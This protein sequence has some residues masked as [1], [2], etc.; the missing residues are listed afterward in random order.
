MLPENFQLEVVTPERRVIRATAV[1]VQVPAQDGYLGVLPGHAPLL[2]AMGNG[3]LSY[4]DGQ[5]T[6]YAAVFGGY[7]EVL[8]GRVIVLAEA[9][10]RAE[11]INS[12]RASAAKQSA[13]KTLAAPSSPE[14]AAAA[15]EAKARAELRL[16]V[17]GHASGA[18]HNA[19]EV[20]HSA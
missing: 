10:E 2:T 1:E 4:N 20:A 7:M 12:A 11:E 18:A 14:E 15:M 9:A 3:E 17:A 6:Y 19:V 13:E 8:A 16:K 5:Q